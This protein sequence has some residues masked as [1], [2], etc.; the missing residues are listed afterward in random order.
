MT[1]SW[2]SQ[3]HIRIV[4]DSLVLKEAVVATSSIS[5][6]EVDRLFTS[7][8]CVVY[9]TCTKICKVSA[10]AEIFMHSLC[11]GWRC[12]RSWNIWNVTW[13]CGVCIQSNSILALSILQNVGLEWFLFDCH[14]W[15]ISL[16]VDILMMTTIFRWLFNRSHLALIEVL[17]A[18]IRVLYHQTSLLWWD[19]GTS[20]EWLFRLDQTVTSRQIMLIF[21]TFIMDEAAFR[22]HLAWPHLIEH[23]V[24]KGWRSAVMINS[25]VL[26]LWPWL[27]LKDTG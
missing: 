2:I 21:N 4:V 1:T 27:V 11:R 25:L 10:H 8:R 15:F 5:L 14:F 24:D 13:C 19:S 9:Q 6:S 7:P 22:R 3:T 26:L 17:L 16:Y 23:G 18:L 12:Y 20:L